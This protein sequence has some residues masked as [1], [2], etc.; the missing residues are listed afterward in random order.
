M[1]EQFVSRASANS[2]LFELLLPRLRKLASSLL[3]SE[4]NG[5]TLR[6][7]ALVH[8][9]Y[10]KL[11]TSTAVALDERHL[12]NLS[13]R[14]MRQILVDYGRKYGSKKHIPLEEIALSLKPVQ[15]SH[16]KAL[17]IEV[18]MQMR[19]LRNLDALVAESLDLRFTAGMK[20]TEIAIVQNRPEWEIRRDCKFGLTWL[21][22][23]IS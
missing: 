13:A 23:R 2:A 14:A 18:N 20:F 10:L 19:N 21:R 16:S 17:N 9:A 1:Q 15:S 7:T 8:E 22:S 5:H 6:T 4:R 12:F 3:R 11:C